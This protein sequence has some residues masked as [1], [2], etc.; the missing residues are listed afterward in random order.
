MSHLTFPK[1]V[2]IIIIIIIIIKIT[3]IIIVKSA[4]A[5][6]VGTNR[7]EGNDLIYIN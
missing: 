4:I 3:I 6:F 5:L 1:G 2:I 7:T